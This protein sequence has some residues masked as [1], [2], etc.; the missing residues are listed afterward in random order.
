MRIRDKEEL[1]GLAS[2]L[3]ELDLLIER[4]TKTEPALKAFSQMSRVLMHNL[5]G[6]LLA[7]LG[8]ETSETYRQLN[9][10][11]TILKDWVRHS[12][13]LA[14]PRPVLVRETLPLKGPSL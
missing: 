5:N 4:V 10:G 3:Q 8:H 14:R 1:A 9:E 13:S 2:R 6:T 7:E 12:L 11:V